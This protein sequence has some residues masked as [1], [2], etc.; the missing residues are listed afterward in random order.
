MNN[1]NTFISPFQSDFREQSPFDRIPSAVLLDGII[2]S[3]LLGFVLGQASKY[4]SAYKDDGWKKRAFVGVVVFLSL[5]QTII[6]E[7][8]LWKM[9]VNRESWV[10]SEFIWTDLAINGFISWMCEAFFIRRCW[11]MTDHNRWVLYPL[12]ILSLSVVAANTFAAVALPIMVHKFDRQTNVY[13]GTALL[14]NALNFT[15]AYWIFGSL[16]LNFLVASILTRSLWRSKTGLKT[17]DRVVW[18]VISLTCESAALPCISMIVAAALFHLQWDRNLLL[19]FVLL[20]GKLYTY[21]LLRTLNSR[22]EFRLRLKSHDLGRVTLSN[23]QWDQG[24][25]E[26]TVVVP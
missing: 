10:N 2:Q 17:S 13:H 24:P 20:S 14:M 3:F 21:G 8:K 25:N 19:L 12:G 9:A 1:N 22:D 26:E 16:L 5:V 4:F 6:E 11:K 18:S 7:I 23:W 15:F